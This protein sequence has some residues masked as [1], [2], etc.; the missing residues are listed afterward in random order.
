M[1]LPE[2]MLLILILALKNQE[3]VTPHGHMPKLQ[4]QCI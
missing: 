3:I 4:L 1:I 2:D